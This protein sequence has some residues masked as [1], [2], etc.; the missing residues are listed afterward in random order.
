MDLIESQSLTDKED[1]LVAEIDIRNDESEYVRACDESEAMTEQ[2]NSLVGQSKVEKYTSVNFT[3]SAE[4]VTDCSQDGEIK[5]EKDKAA[6]VTD[7]A[8]IK[9]QNE[10]EFSLAG[11]TE[12][13][14]DK[15]ANAAVCA[16]SCLD[17]VVEQIKD[18][19]VYV[20]VEDDIAVEEG[21]DQTDIDDNADIWK[22]MRT[23][24]EFS[25]VF[26]FELLIAQCNGSMLFFQCTIFE[27]FNNCQVLVNFI[28]QL[29][30]TI[31]EY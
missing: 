10:K 7:G 15:D 28:V 25:K 12:F 4:R 26:G 22:E 1:F 5:F 19:G 27:L 14:K 31:S 11:D 9:A 16:E 23:A 24:L 8:D 2:D 17:D 29:V 21:N 3:D 20:G 30:D 13:Q 6:N 18:K